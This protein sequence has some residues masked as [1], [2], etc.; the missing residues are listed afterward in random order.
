MSATAATLSH[1]PSRRA[2][3]KLIVT[4][5]KCAWR[6]PVSLAL[7]VLVPVVILVILGSVGALQKTI[8]GSNPPV[9]YMTTFIPVLIGMVLALTALVSLP[10]VLVSQRETAFLRRLST[11]PVAPRWLLAA[12]V[13]VNFALA[14]VAILL[15]VAGGTLF[16]HVSAPAQLGGF[17]LSAL[18]ATA[19]LF[20]VGL[21]IAAVAANR[22][23]AAVLGTLLFYPLMFFAGL[24]VPRQSMAP[25]MRHISDY[26]PLGAGVHAMLSSIQGSFPPAQPLLVM[27]AWAVVFGVAAVKLFRWE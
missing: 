7:G 25:G 26:T 20:A 2:L 3:K 4:E 15:I 12:Q 13:A 6:A 17:V 19:A 5:A 10:I 14:V 8:P 27:G 21:L 9:T 23:V 1:R 22:V 18:L 11:T 24:W 16:F